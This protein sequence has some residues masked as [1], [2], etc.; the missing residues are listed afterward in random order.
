MRIHLSLA[1]R[2]SRRVGVIGPNRVCKSSTAQSAG[3]QS[4][5][6]RD[7]AKVPHLPVLLHCRET[8]PCLPFGPQSLV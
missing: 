2:Q 8:P 3:V 7:V 5:T 1:L 6:A 4:P